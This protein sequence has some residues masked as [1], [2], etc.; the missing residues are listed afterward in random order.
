M[1]GALVI[2][3]DEIDRFFAEPWS[4]LFWKILILLAPI[5]WVLLW[6]LRELWVDYQQGKFAGKQQFVVLAIDVPR[7]SEQTI[8]AV[9]HIFNL[10]KGTKSVITMKEKW[11]QGKYWLSTSFEIAS[12]DGYI[13]FFIRTST[14]Y[15][16]MFEA[17][18]YSVYPDAEISEV[19]DYTKN[20]PDD[21][22][23]DTHEV[24]G[25][26]LKLDKPS[27]FP[28]RTW[29]EFEHTVSKE[30]VFKDPLISL[31]EFMGKLKQGEQFWVHLIINPGDSEKPVKDGQEW[32]L[33]TYGKEIPVKKS[34][35]GKFAEPVLWFPRETMSQ[36]GA[37]LPGGET[38]EEKPLFKF[39]V[40]TDTQKTQLKGV[41]VK[42]SKEG[43]YCKIRWG[44]VA[45]HE[46][47]NKGGRNTLWKSYISL[48]SH[49]DNNKFKYDPDTMPR[50]DY[51]WMIWEY[52]N[53]Q[54]TLMR[55]LKS[56]SWA[57]GTTP[58][59]LN[60]EELA[61]L[62][63]FPSIDVQAPLIKKT[64]YKLGEA[65]TS[66]PEAKFGE[67]DELP[68]EPLVE[69]DEQG[70]PIAY[71]QTAAPSHGEKKMRST[72]LSSEDSVDDILPEGPLVEY[73]EVTAS[74]DAA[75]QDDEL[76]Q[77]FT[78]PNLPT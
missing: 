19:E 11:I 50:D 14:G 13:Q 65:P 68:A 59:Y 43:Y 72:G 25:G 29:M 56:R 35:L 3:I 12:I 75:S 22:P 33:K 1:V 74:T 26:E 71:T 70:R 16:D 52:R 38:K 55:A 47:Y 46:V 57:V 44:Y 77:P 24:F 58:M 10:V 8:K 42:L 53:K 31:F 27:Y 62:W 64:Q 34:K 36:I 63:H 51:F 45:R 69:V 20:L 54:R 40:A 4:Y 78:P 48:F 23:N 9:E 39:F 18:I 6:G 30:Q 41:S 2:N 67:S 61:T 21:Y 49:Y 66:L 15:R 17:A 28:L 73:D 5:V 37:L 76:E 32:I 60:I 7:N